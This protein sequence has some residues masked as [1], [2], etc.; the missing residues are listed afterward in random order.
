M[1]SVSATICILPRPE[2]VMLQLRL[3]VPVQQVMSVWISMR[4]VSKVRAPVDL[5]IE[6]PKKVFVNEEEEEDTYEKQLVENSSQLSHTDLSKT[7]T[8]YSSMEQTNQIRCQKSKHCLDDD[9]ISEAHTETLT[10][11][12]LPRVK[13]LN[14]EEVHSIDSALLSAEEQDLMD[15]SSIEADL[16]SN[17][18][19]KSPNTY[20]TAL[21]NGM[22]AERRVS[23]ARRISAIQAARRMSPAVNG[24]G[25]NG[26]MICMED[27]QSLRPSSRSERRISVIGGNSSLTSMASHTTT[28]TTLRRNVSAFGEITVMPVGEEADRDVTVAVEEELSHRG[29]SR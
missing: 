15:S 25:G 2:N 17:H 7:N 4:S 16:A 14:D 6:R 10:L 27:M 5:A 8:V 21:N 26:Q 23:N 20:L 22:T 11:E 18:Y 28:P 9:A 29:H 3:E 1:E 24:G 13:S 12:E 19:R